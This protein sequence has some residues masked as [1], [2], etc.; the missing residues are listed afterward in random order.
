MKFIALFLLAIIALSACIAT[1]SAENPE[2]QLRR[3]T[4]QAC[5]NIYEL[6]KKFYRK[7]FPDSFSQKIATDGCNLEPEPLRTN[8]LDI[9]NHIADLR[10][11]IERSQKAEE[12]C[13][14]L[15]YCH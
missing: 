9:A 2:E 10:H 12:A 7:Q 1:V 13:F 11:Q 5:R 4:C 6:T 8:C 14:N 15:H 3:E